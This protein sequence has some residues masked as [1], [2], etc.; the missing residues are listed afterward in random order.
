M[1]IKPYVD[2][3]C[4][5]RPFLIP[6]TAE[7]RIQRFWLRLRLVNASRI[8]F[9][10]IRRRA[11]LRVLMPVWTACEKEARQSMYKTWLSIWYNMPII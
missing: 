11:Y 5:T 9:A 7:M 2:Y 4:W 6:F 1:H 10:R 3:I 8:V